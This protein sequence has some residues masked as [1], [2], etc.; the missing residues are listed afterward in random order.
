MTREIRRCTGHARPTD[1]RGTA[2]QDA[3]RRRWL[4][5]TTLRRSRASS[6][7]LHPHRLNEK[8]E[9]SELD[10]QPNETPQGLRHQPASPKTSRGD[11]RLVEDSRLLPEDAVPRDA[12]NRTLGVHHSSGLQLD[13]D[14][15]PTAR[16]NA[17]PKR[18][19]PRK[20]TSH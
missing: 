20:K 10:G 11:I 16:L 17:G 5:R 9:A 6:Q 2:P 14:G 7:N 18:S 3:R 1:G 13:E 8:H 12:T 19:D 4:R 15:A